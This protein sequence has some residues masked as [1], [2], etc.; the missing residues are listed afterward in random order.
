M[1]TN[2]K[3]IRVIDGDTFATDTRYIRLANVDAPEINSQGGR[4]ATRKLQSLINGKTVSI[5]EVGTSYGRKVAEVTFNR[6]S[7]NQMM[8]DFLK[9]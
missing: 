3:V 1:T 6:A 8:R 9:Q 5:T 7:I 2:E 4:A